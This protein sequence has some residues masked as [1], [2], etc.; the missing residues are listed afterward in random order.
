MSNQHGD[1]IRLSSKLQSAWSSCTSYCTL[2]YSV[3][4]LYIV[5]GGWLPIPKNSQRVRPNKLSFMLPWP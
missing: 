3:V 4:R 2:L 1:L 5:Y